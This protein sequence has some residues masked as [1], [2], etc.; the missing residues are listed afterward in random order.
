MQDTNPVLEFCLLRHHPSWDFVQHFRK[1]GSLAKKA[2]T[3]MLLTGHWE[4]SFLSREAAGRAWK[5]LS[6][7]T[8][9]TTCQYLLGLTVP[10]LTAAHISAFAFL[11]GM[12]LPPSFLFKRSAFNSAKTT[13]GLCKSRGTTWHLE[14]KASV[15]STP[16]LWKW[17]VI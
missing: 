12:W 2:V 6:V 4:D 13:P 15:K 11:R 3:L 1:L 10:H 5:G 8:G 9:L 17:V 14:L 7:S 16:L